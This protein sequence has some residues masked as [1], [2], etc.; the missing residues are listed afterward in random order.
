VRGVGLSAR[1]T[2]LDTVPN[3]R[4]PEQATAE[5]QHGSRFRNFR[6]GT[7]QL[8]GDRN[9]GIAARCRIGEVV[10]VRILRDFPDRAVL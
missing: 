2:R 10:D 5:Q 9:T 6:G 3:E 7:G 1:T 8:H 4:K